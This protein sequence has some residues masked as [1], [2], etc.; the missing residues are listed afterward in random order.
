MTAIRLLQ[1][2]ELFSMY[3]FVAE[4]AAPYCVRD[5]GYYFPIDLF[6]VIVNSVCSADVRPTEIN[7]I[8]PGV[9]YSVKLRSLYFH[10][11]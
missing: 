4:L 3:L 2:C 9:F 10:V 11:C 1:T 7:A 5:F 6:G 8:A